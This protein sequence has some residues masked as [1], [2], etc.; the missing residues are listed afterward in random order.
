MRIRVFAHLIPLLAAIP[1][2]AAPVCMQ[3]GTLQ[4]YLDVSASDG[5]CQ[6]DNFQMSNWAFA[7]VGVFAQPVTASNI[8]VNYSI[9]ASGLPDISFS[10]TWTADAFPLADATSVIAYSIEA[11]NNSYIITGVGISAEGSVSPL[12]AGLVPT[13]AAALTE[14]NC[15][16]GLTDIRDPG[17]LGGVLPLPGNLGDVACSGGSAN[18]NTTA[19]LAPGVGVSANANVSFGAGDNFIDIVKILV[20]SDLLNVPLSGVDGFGTLTS[21]SQQFQGTAVPAQTPEPTTLS[22]MGVGGLLLAWARRRTVRS[23][24]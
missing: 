1:A 2:A 16:G 5:G 7:T 4:S 19:S 18:V 22:M 6:I 17:N 23:R 14:L 24:A 10:G 20:V 13:G 12:T 15:V 11:L 21:V 3:G 8:V 9:N